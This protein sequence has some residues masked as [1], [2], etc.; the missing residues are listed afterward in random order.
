VTLFDLVKTFQEVLE[1]SQHR[2]VIQVNGESVSVQQM[3]LYLHSLLL[4]R[5]RGE[6]I[7]VRELFERQ[8]TR[9][10]LICLFL[11]LLELAKLGAI[12]LVQRQAFGDIAL[13]AHQRFDEVMSSEHFL[14]NIEKGYH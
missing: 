6:A 9:Q 1:R 7:A 13:R 3:I 8:P 11:A 5:P 10:A 14:N 12:V 2:P 4:G